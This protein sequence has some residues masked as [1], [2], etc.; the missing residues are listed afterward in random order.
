MMMNKCIVNVCKAGN[1]LLCAGE[2]LGL[3]P[4]GW[5][6]LAHQVLSDTAASRMQQ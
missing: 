2:L 1:E 3:W 5:L 6:P 4:L